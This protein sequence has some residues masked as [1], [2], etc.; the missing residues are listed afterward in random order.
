VGVLSTKYHLSIRK[1][2]ALLEQ[3]LGVRISTGTTAGIR[4]HL[5]DVLEAPVTEANGADRIQRVLR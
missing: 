5:G 1:V 3:L 2:Q 4:D